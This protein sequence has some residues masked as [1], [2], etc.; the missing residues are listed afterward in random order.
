MKWDALTLFVEAARGGS[1]SAAARVAHV[2]PS[3]VSRRVAELEDDVGTRLFQRSTR[4]MV[5]T[6]AG[7]IYYQRVAQL[8]EELERASDFAHDTENAAR[9]LLRVA[10]PSSFA[11]EHVVPWLV[12]LH[13]LYPA[14]RIE[15]VLHSQMSDLIEERIDV[16]I[17]L[18]HMQPSS[19]IAVKLC[20][21]PRVIVASPSYLEK[22]GWP[23]SP[24]D[25]NTHTCLAFPFEGFKHIW[26]LRDATG[27]EISVELSPQIIAAEGMILRALAL[28][29][30]GVSLL[31]RWMIASQLRE[32]SLVNIFPRYDATATIHGAAVWLVYPS[33]E[34]L[35]L[36]VR[37]FLDYV[38]ARFHNG[39]PWEWTLR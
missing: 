18:G 13:A 9:G 32:G 31:P 4:R 14:L 36:K 28:Q 23:Q 38:K 17:R 5:L 1:F 25:L 27:Q 2:S 21:M 26:S 24:A 20:E 22:A 10:T 39:P 37:V 3:H 6:D 29:G 19:L 12:E 35:P 11:H 30:Q 33:R 16:A 7:R 8:L 34:H 15:L